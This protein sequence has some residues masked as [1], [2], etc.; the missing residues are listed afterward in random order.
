MSFLPKSNVRILEKNIQHLWLQS[1]NKTLLKFQ[2][3]T[4]CK[5]PLKR[6][7][8][9]QDQLFYKFL[10]CQG[11]RWVEDYR[12]GWTGRRASLCQSP[13]MAWTVLSCYTGHLLWPT[14]PLGPPLTAVGW[15][16][17][18]LCEWASDP[19]WGSESTGVAMATAAGEEE[20]R[21]RSWGQESDKED[22]SW[23]AEEEGA[24]VHGSGCLVQCKL[25]TRTATS[26]CTTYILHSFRWCPSLVSLTCPTLEEMLRNKTN[27]E[28][29]GRERQM[30]T[31]SWIYCFSQPEARWTFLSVSYPSLEIEDW[32]RSQKPTHCLIDLPCFWKWPHLYIAS[33]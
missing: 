7:L 11:K 9:K 30:M 5:W 15:G 33:L 22:S 18:Q 8:K 17:A 13:E 25:G 32:K 3:S 31:P 23:N 21:D 16:H 20:L 4:F 6:G 1:I 14:W 10:K 28:E 27:S 29:S 12:K 26:S 2:L 24:S 19:G